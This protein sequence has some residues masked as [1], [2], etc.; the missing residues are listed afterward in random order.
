MIA[1][2]GLNDSTTSVAS[3]SIALGS[4]YKV[5]TGTITYN[6]VSYD[7][8]EYFVGTATTTFTGT[9]TIALGNNKKGWHYRSNC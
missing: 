3:G 8:G 5:L 6:A 1:Y 2:I 9:G 4:V 7:A